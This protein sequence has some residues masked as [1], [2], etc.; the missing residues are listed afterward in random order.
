MTGTPGGAVYSVPRKPCWT[1]SALA[2]LRVMTSAASSARNLVLT[3]TTMP[4]AVS[5]PNAAIIQSAELGAQIATGS[6]FSIPDSANAPA[7]QR[8]LSTSSV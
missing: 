4:P 1:N 5:S 2:R 7:A 3:G 8:I 6:P